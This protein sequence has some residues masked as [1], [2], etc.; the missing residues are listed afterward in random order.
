MQIQGP[1]K[2]VPL[3]ES[4]TYPGFHSSRVDCIFD[5]G[6]KSAL[7]QYQH[8]TKRLLRQGGHSYL[9]SI[10]NQVLGIGIKIC[11]LLLNLAALLQGALLV[12]ALL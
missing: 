12:D 5:R 10:L 4:S 6:D 9:N 3:N 8:V 7:H 2:L 11:L 1:E